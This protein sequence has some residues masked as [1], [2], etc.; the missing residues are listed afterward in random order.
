MTAIPDPTRDLPSVALGSMLENVLREVKEWQNQV[1]DGFAALNSDTEYALRMRTR[2]LLAEYEAVINS[3][4]PGPLTQADATLRER[5]LI[6]AQQA[7]WDLFKDACMIAERVAETLGSAKPH[8]FAGLP[9]VAPEQLVA[10]LA[11]PRP[12]RTGT[13]LPARL[14]KVFRPGW[15]GIMMT[16]IVTKLLDVQVPGLVLAGLAA[17]G[18]A[19]MGGAAYTGERK[20]QLDRRR[21]DAVSA[22]RGTIEDFRL[23]LGK[24]L[25]DASRALQRDLRRVSSATAAE[26][27]SDLSTELKMARGTRLY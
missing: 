20:R 12:P 25:R 23:T 7:Y 13:P 14:L 4:D 5:L 18:A 24:Q 11:P 2:A 26:K 9:V 6:E 17:L 22:V 10:G 19:L 27:V 3:T 8:T 15:S 16:L 21:A 1:G